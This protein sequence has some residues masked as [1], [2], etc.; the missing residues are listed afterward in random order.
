M[1]PFARGALDA[2]TKI[3]ALSASEKLIAK[4]MLVGAGAGGI[5]SGLD[6]YDHSGKKPGESDARF[7]N[8]RL[9]QSATAA[10]KGAGTGAGLGL[11]TGMVHSGRGKEVLERL[12]RQ[13][14]GG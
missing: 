13:R 5:Y 1:T 2:M 3:A 9:R 14:M 6:R 11:V 7:K 8:R 12:L 10:L 4:H